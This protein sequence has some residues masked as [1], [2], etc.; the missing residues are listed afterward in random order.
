[1]ATE[2]RVADVDGEHGMVLLD[3]EGIEF[4]VR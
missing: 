4:C 3:P 2:Q 1:M